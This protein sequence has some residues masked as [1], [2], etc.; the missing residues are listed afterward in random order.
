[1]SACRFSLSIPTHFSNWYYIC[2]QTDCFRQQSHL[3]REQNPP[4]FLNR[5][6]LEPLPKKDETVGIAPPQASVDE[7]TLMK[8]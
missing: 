6:V 3:T 7:P 8:L 1:M 4:S 5:A 2:R